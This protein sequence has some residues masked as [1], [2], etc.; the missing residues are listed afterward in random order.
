FKGFVTSDW[1]ATHAVTFINAGLD[2]EMPGEP[3][4]KAR[5]WSL[6]TYFDSRPILPPPPPAKPR[7]DD[8]GGDMFGGHMPEEPPPEPEEDAAASGKV[9]Y[10]KMPQALEDGTVSEAAVTRAAGRV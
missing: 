5:D 1:G 7:A 10:R 4:L 3:P 2:M 6:P 8:V 9:H